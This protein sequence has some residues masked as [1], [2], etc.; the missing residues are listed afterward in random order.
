MRLL[1]IDHADQRP[2]FA[3]GAVDP[4]DAVVLRADG[5]VAGVDVLGDVLESFMLERFEPQAGAVRAA[6]N[7]RTLIIDA[8]HRGFAFRTLHGISRGGRSSVTQ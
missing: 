1:R 7:E 5:S 6:L 8:F 3:L 2:V 4:V